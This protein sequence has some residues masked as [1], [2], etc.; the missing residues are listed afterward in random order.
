MTLRPEIYLSAP[1]IERF[2]SETPAKN[3]QGFTGKLALPFEVVLSAKE[4]A[5]LTLSPTLYLHRPAFGGGNLQLHW[6]M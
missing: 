2:Y 1:D 5:I 4:N 3:H 6:P